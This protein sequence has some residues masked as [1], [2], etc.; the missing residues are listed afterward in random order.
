MKYGNSDHL[1]SYGIDDH[2]GFIVVEPPQLYSLFCRFQVFHMLY[3][4]KWTSTTLFPHTVRTINPQ[5]NRLP[6]L[7]GDASI[8]K[9]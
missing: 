8:L 6:L 3:Q 4:G 9:T 5:L 1:L 7:Q 2:L